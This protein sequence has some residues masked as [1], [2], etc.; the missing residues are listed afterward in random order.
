MLGTPSSPVDNIPPV[1]PGMASGAVKTEGRWTVALKSKSYPK[2]SRVY[3]YL[4][5]SILKLKLTGFRVLQHMNGSRQRSF[6]FGWFKVT[7]LFR[8]NKNSVKY[9]ISFCISNIIILKFAL[10]VPVDMLFIVH[11]VSA[12]PNPRIWGSNPACCHNISPDYLP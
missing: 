11:A 4:S 7:Q 1:A 12:N 6:A 9:S 8:R 3:T 10:S 2:R 5:L